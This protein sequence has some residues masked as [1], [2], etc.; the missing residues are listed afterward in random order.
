MGI[1]VGMAT[2]I[3]PH[4][5]GELIDATIAQINKPEITLDETME[6]IKGPDFP[7]GG[8]I[9]G[10]ESIRTAFATGRGGVV[11]RGLANIEETAK[12]GRHRIVITEIPYA[13]NKAG[14]VEKIADLVREK[15]INGIS[16]IRDES[17]RAAFV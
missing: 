12:A 1:A 7:T 13:V 8:V 17:A 6:H 10:R 5:L 3:P 16:D 9:Y 4:N 15:K 11:V 2:N 14:L